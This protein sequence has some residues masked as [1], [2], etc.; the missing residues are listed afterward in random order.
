M[1]RSYDVLV[2]G[3]GPAGESAALTASRYGKTVAVVER[4]RALGGAAV[5]TGTVPSK[6]L[7]E[8]AVAL[9]GLRTRNLH[10]VDLSLRRDATLDD[11]LTH[12]RS[13]RTGAREHIAANLAAAGVAV[14]RGT[15][16]FVDPHT[17]AVGSEHYSAKCIIIATGSYPLR[18]A[19]F[20]FE[21]NR[22]HDSDELLE[23][24]ALPRSIAVIG[25]GVI[26]AEYACTFAALGVPV[27][28]IDGRDKLLPFLDPSLSAGLEAAMT[29]LGVEF[30]WK[31][32][33]SACNS[34]DVGDITLTFANGTTRSFDHVLVCAGRGARTAELNVGAAGLVLADKGRFAVDANYRTNVAHIYAAGDVIG[35]PALASTSAE[36]GRAAAEHFCCENCHPVAPV[37]PTGI[38]TIPEVS[39]AGE[40]EPQLIA[41]NIGY[42]VGI[43]HYS[44][45]PRGRIIGDRHGF[46]KCLFEKDT[47]KLLGVH[48]LGEQASELLHIGV[49]VM[50]QSAGR[51]LLLRTC[52]NYPTLGELYK[53]CALRA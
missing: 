20:A 43:A 42:T 24:H 31:H 47:G 33:V 4:E 10:G 9:S 29:D 39:S 52:F 38:Y 35:F 8:T 48:A 28:L 17:V 18:P 25:A 7:R 45:V 32:A 27:A 21:H 12:E 5:N 44:E 37:L 50:M 36:Q 51:E 40:T 23:L 19:G 49:L 2:L 53:L 15:A 1:I 14:L 13:V 16:S 34:P 6:T 3:A 46:L 26:G 30:V 41:K 11:F 22:V